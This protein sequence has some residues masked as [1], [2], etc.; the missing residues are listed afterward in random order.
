[1]GADAEVAQK[2]DFYRFTLSNIAKDIKTKVGD[3]TARCGKSGVD[4]DPRIF[5]PIMPSMR[6]CFK[7]I[8]ALDKQVAPVGLEYVK[9][10]ELGT[11]PADDTT[12]FC[13]QV[14]SI[15]TM[16]QQALEPIA[17]LVEDKGDGSIEVIFLFCA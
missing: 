14:N 11:V 3:F 10:A 6:G 8:V 2:L 9:C 13:S 12:K 15:H 4:K 7:A 1:M 16:L 5:D 17:K